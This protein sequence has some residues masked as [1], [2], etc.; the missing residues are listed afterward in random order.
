MNVLTTTQPAGEQI[1][2]G[3]PQKYVAVQGA[4]GSLAS[5]LQGVAT[6]S[7]ATTQTS[8]TAAV[9]AGLAG[10]QYLVTIEAVVQTPGATT[11]TLELLFGGVAQAAFT[12]TINTQAGLSANLDWTGIIGIADGTSVTARIT[13]GA[14]NLAAVS[15]VGFVAIELSN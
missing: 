6:S 13:S 4:A 12:T 7:G 8:T 1:E 14:G 2:V 11:V 3:G 15:R 9:A 5:V 10:K